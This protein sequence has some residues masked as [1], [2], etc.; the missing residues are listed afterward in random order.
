MVNHISR[1]VNYP[2]ERYYFSIF[3]GCS[4]NK[5]SERLGSVSLVHFGI[6]HKSLKYSLPVVKNLNLPLHTNTNH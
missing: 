5:L 2:D 3:H 4:M 1:S 6:S